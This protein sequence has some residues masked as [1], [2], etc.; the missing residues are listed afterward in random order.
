MV[1]TQPR[2]VILV[3]VFPFNISFLICYSR[4]V[5]SQRGQYLQYRRFPLGGRTQSQ[6][7]KYN[8]IQ[9]RHIYVFISVILRVILV[10]LHKNDKI[11]RVC[12]QQVLAEKTAF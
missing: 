12:L 2:L 1:D 4:C 9:R 10:P 3:Y 8:R 5:V 6:S 11:K 7:Q